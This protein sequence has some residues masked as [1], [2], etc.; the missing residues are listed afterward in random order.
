MKRYRHDFPLLKREYKGQE[1]IY[2]DNA[3]TT[4]KPQVVLDAVGDYY[5]FHNANINRGPNF[6]SEE[7]TLLYESARADVAAFI[8][9]RSEEIVF[10]SGSTASINIIARSLGDW[11][12]KAG[13]KVI[14]SR[15]E[16]HSNLIPW[17]QLKESLGIQIGYIGL[18]GEGS[19]LQSDIEGMLTDP[20]VK[21][22]SL[23]QASNVIGRYYDLKPILAAAR[24]RE[25]ITVVDSSQS[26][27]HR[28]VDVIDLGCDFL[29]F[30]GHKMFAPAGT[31]VLYARRE[32]LR[33]MPP[34]FGGGGMVSEVNFDG[35]KAAEGPAKLEAGT[36]NIE[37][38][39]G[40]GAAC[41][42][43]AGRRA[44]MF[45][46]EESLIGHFIHKLQENGNGW[47]LVGG[48][49]GRLPLF[50]FDLG[51]D[52]HPHDAAD[53]LGERGIIV[54]AGR[55]CAHPLHD[56]LGLA[57]SLRASLA[58]YNNEEEVDEFFVALAEI[59]RSLTA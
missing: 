9:A 55:H 4:P 48:L 31:G 50:S 20:T 54:R 39:I 1:L 49:Q 47:R 24:K 21:V 43:I 58:F 51:P 57:G 6:L 40:L 15:A 29:V 28:Q 14:L 13:D 8:G 27:P 45:A 26:I 18:D 11:K 25:I 38:A 7:A 23:T 34:V 44:E 36:P 22:L 3:A 30:S 5:L 19:F 32:I 46:Q 33:D 37:G 12:L 16:H 10:T 17:M 53:L 35:Y 42:Y 52:L 59:R 56:I 2:F 41:N